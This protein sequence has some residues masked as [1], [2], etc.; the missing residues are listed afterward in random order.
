ML[1]KSLLGH[2]T[3][4]TNEDEME[5]YDEGFETEGYQDFNHQRNG[6]HPK[7]RI[8]TSLFSAIEVSLVTFNNQECLPNSLVNS[9]K[10]LFNRFKVLLPDTVVV[11]VMEMLLDKRNHLNRVTQ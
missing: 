10:T 5:L 7:L 2:D 11:V 9:F 3:A 1:I 6:V 8:R 4:A